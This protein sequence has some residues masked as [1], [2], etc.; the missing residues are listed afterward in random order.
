MQNACSFEKKVLSEANENCT[1]SEK[2]L[3]KILRNFQTYEIVRR[4]QRTEEHFTLLLLHAISDKVALS[5]QSKRANKQRSTRN[6]LTKNGNLQAADTKTAAYCS[7]FGGSWP[8]FRLTLPQNN[9][10]C[11]W[12]YYLKAVQTPSTIRILHKQ[13]KS[14]LVLSVWTESREKKIYRTTSIAVIVTSFT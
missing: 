12:K 9:H 7:I 8:T 11:V 10:L 4:F 13:I 3:Q 5:K 14:Q 6:I 1:L 2:E